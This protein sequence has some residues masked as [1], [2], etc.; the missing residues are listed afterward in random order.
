[1]NGVELI[2]AGFSRR[3][4]PL[5]HRRDRSSLL[6]FAFAHFL[7]E[8]TPL[9]RLV[10][11]SAFILLVSIASF[12]ATQKQIVPLTAGWEFH[13]LISRVAAGA[14]LPFACGLGIALFIAGERIFGFALGLAAG[15]IF[16][17]LAVGCCYAFQYIRRLHTGVEERAT[18]ARRRAMTENTSLDQRITQ[19]LSEARVVLPG[20]KPCSG[21]S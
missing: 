3:H 6:L 13:Q 14:L 1:M 17:T 18:S 19:M 5:D 12:A 2:G 9:F 10:L 7:K 21:F 11:R 8:H 16:T 20:C 4:L 15:C